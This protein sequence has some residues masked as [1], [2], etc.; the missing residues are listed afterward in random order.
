M[1]L[2]LVKSSRL[3]Q[4]A[5]FLVSSNLQISFWFEKAELTQS[6]EIT[7]N[8]VNIFN[9]ISTQIKLNFLLNF[10]SNIKVTSRQ[11]FSAICTF[12]LY[13]LMNENHDLHQ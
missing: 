12:G 8:E 7:Q 13:N 10:C 1:K 3:L 11:I 4:R 6:A 5:V 2:S 9:K